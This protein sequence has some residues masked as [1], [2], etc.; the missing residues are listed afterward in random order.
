VGYVY[1]KAD[2]KNKDELEHMNIIVTCVA[3]LDHSTTTGLCCS[4]R[5]ARL[6]WGQGFRQRPGS[7]PDG[8]WGLADA[9]RRAAS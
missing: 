8:A 4:F 9:G 1:I 3:Y 2:T 7:G 6:Q 5:P